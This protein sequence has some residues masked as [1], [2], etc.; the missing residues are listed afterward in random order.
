MARHPFEVDC[1]ILAHAGDGGNQVGEDWWG[2]ARRAAHSLTFDLDQGG[3]VISPNLRQKRRFIMD[4][5]NY[6]TMQVTL[7][8][9]ILVVA[10]AVSAYFSR[11][12]R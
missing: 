3:G 2:A 7:A 9:A 8:I 10:F 11:H 6:D 5:I 12:F 4:A 1:A